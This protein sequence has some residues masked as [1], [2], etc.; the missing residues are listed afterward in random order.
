[1]LWIF[2]VTNINPVPAIAIAQWESDKVIYPLKQVSKLE[3]RFNDFSEL[4]DD[5]KQELPILH[6]SDYQK[7]AT[8]NWGYNDYT[9]L[10]TVLWWASYKYW[11]DM[12]YGWHIGTDIATAKWTPVYTIADWK[13]TTVK[14][15]V[16]EWNYIT[17]E[18]TIKWKKIFS[19]YM[20]LSKTDVTVGQT[21]TVW[22][23]IWEVWSTWN[24]TGNHLHVQ[25]DLDTTNV[26]PFY[27][28]YNSCPYSY[29]KITEE[30]ICFNELAQNTI[31]PLKFF[32]TSWAV[33]DN[34]STQT[35]TIP[36]SSTSTNTSTKTNTTNNSSNDLSIFD[37]TVYI[38]YDEEDIKKVQE[39]YQKIGIYKWAINWKYEDVEDSVFQYQV[40]KWILAKKSDSWAGWFGP[41]TRSTTKQDYLAYL[42][43][44]WTSITSTTNTNTNTSNNNNVQ[45]VVSNKVETQKIEK[46]NLMSREEIEKREVEEFLRLYNIDLR[47]INQWWNIQK[48]NTETLKLNITNRK[49][50]AFKWEMP[51]GMT[52][53]V[54]T[55]K[56]NVFPEKLFFF[57]D[58]QRDIKLTW[59]KEWDTNLYVKVWNQVIK[60]ISLKVYNS[61]VAQYPKSSS[62]IWANST[63]LW[64]KQTWVVV[65]KDANNKNMI[66]LKYGS[67]Y[68]IKASGDNKICI[69]QWSIKDLK[70]IYTVSC[71]ES[72]YKNEANFT[73]DNTVWWMLVFDYKATSKDFNIVVK[74]NYDWKILSEK[75]YTVTNPK[76]LA[77]NYEYKNEVIS[78]LEQWIADWINKWYFMEARWLT[79]KDALTWIENS[80]TKIQKKVYDNQTN[81][82]INNNL[83]DIKTAKLNASKSKTITRLEF[84]N[85]SYKYLV[86][87]PAWAGKKTYKDI[88]EETSKKLAQIFD[89]KTTWKDQF[90]Q[91]YFRPDSEITRWEWAYLLS[92]TLE[93]NAQAYLTLK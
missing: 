12:W 87:N 44:W 86:L 90:G 25:I 55:E 75:K 9:R 84:L 89:E 6:T 91:S 74:N 34:I 83:Y 56:V 13:V 37:R 39:I 4:T 68:N 81:T 92:K 72:D 71:N 85:L 18:H 57:T 20:H 5:C 14:N 58:W 48:W 77:S 2:L 26:H 23:K 62:I 61:Q 36:K 19:T 24:S 33:L 28:G 32:E 31:D 45:V 27:Y 41:K 93:K 30:W 67:T 40:S 15:G 82:T 64:W 79:Q 88:D 10:Y 8:L 43:G 73:Y 76:W 63:V 35:V 78:M 50:V 42:A 65:F 69:K 17:I 80:L 70:K 29:Y 59:V 60:T 52:F 53:V 1:M 49:W 21:L 66:N 22:T 38:W 7:Y 3:C 47:L 51:G 46:T 11:W 16:M 54:N